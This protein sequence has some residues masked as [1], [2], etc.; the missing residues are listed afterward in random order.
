VSPVQLDRSSSD[1]LKQNLEQR[2]ASA[3]AR[4]A[5]DSTAK[6]AA[7]KAT[8]LPGGF[9]DDLTPTLPTS[10]NNTP[11]NIVLPTSSNTSS[12]NS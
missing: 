1:D 8:I 4:V 6:V 3:A 5:A 11:L 7:E 2:V 9:Q 12:G 10:S